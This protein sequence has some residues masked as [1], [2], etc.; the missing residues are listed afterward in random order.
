VVKRV[1]GRRRYYYYDFFFF[2]TLN[3][4]ILGIVMLSA[5]GRATKSPKRETN[6]AA[7]RGR[8]KSRPVI[9]FGGWRGLG[10]DD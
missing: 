8:E 1:I 5:P 2:W 7:R 10:A 3:V 9:G 4:M 6:F